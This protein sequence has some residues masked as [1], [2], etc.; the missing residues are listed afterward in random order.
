MSP[1]VVFWS[2][3][4]GGYVYV[5]IVLIPFVA[6]HALMHL[7]RRWMLAVYSILTWLTLY[8]MANRF[9][10][11]QYLTPVAPGQ[12]VLLYLAILAIAGSIALSYSRKIGNRR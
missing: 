4:H 1:L 7:P 9:T 8:A 12:D 5:F 11:H 10:H 2:N 6:W 3:V